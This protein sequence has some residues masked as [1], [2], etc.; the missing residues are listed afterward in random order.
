MAIGLRPAAARLLFFESARGMT[1]VYNSVY[2]YLHVQIPDIQSILLDELPP[3]LHV[4][5]HERGEDLVGHD[6][7]LQI[8][9]EQRA[10]L[11][12]R[13]KGS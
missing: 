7:I 2:R 8:N 13:I 11:D 1:Q 5:A 3:A 6:Q 9:F 4:L 10:R 12:V